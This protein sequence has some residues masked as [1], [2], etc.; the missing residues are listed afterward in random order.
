M[1]QPYRAVPSTTQL[2]AMSKDPGNLR[3]SAE[4]PPSMHGRKPDKK[5]LRMQISQ[6][7]NTSFESIILS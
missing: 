3:V 4:Q 1:F 6:L 7:A 5:T 2:V